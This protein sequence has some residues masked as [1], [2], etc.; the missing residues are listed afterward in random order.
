MEQLDLKEKF[1]RLLNFSFRTTLKM[2]TPDNTTGTTPKLQSSAPVYDN[3][4]TM[5][6]NSMTP[7]RN[8]STYSSPGSGRG[9]RKMLDALGILR[10]IVIDG[11]LEDINGLYLCEDP[12]FI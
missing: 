2:T 5:N 7:K 3:F 10:D 1:V 12:T 11:G 9:V 6:N 4:E 8:K